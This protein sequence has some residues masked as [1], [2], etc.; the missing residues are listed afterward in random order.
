MTLKTTTVAL[1]ALGLIALVFGTLAHSEEDEDPMAKLAELRK[2]TQPGKQHERL[3]F[4]LG[5]W[6]VEMKMTMPGA[7]E[8]PATKA[9]STF[10]WA[11]EGRWLMER[12]EGSMMGQPWTSVGLH[13]FDNYAK[14]FVSATVSNMDTAL[15][16][17]KGV[18]TNPKEDVVVQYGTFGEYMLG[19]HNHPNR[20][21]TR[22]T[23]DD[24]FEL[25]IWDLGIGESGA[26]VIEMR[27][28]R[29]AEPDED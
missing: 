5:A 28:T 24:S 19:D 18:V 15:Y 27:Y 22:K 8:M 14:N 25:E 9:K 23:G 1:A 29:K 4:F 16:V 7:P 20:T 21:V 2:V 3:S 6:D 11:I 26:K 10:T 13:G 12:F 17:M